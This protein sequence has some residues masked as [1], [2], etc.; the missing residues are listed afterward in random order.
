M[1]IWKKKNK[2]NL[3]YDF[4]ALKQLVL[5]GIENLKSQIK[6]LFTDNIKVR[7]YILH[8]IWIWQYECIIHNID[9]S[10]QYPWHQH[11]SVHGS[12]YDLHVQSSLEQ[13]SLHLQF[14][15]SLQTWETSDSVVQM[16]CALPCWSIFHPHC[17]KF[18]TG[19]SNIAQRLQRYSMNM[20]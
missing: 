11:I 15:S 6:C 10:S 3:V 16:S 5:T 19:S 20:L 14:L 17:A 4:I 13:N 8:T 2:K 7:I 9:Q 12:P 1:L 18:I